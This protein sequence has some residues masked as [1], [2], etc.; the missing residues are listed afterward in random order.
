MRYSVGTLRRYTEQAKG[1]LN[2]V[3]RLPSGE[4]AEL[5][6]V[7]S[8]GNRKIGAAP[9]VSLLPIITCGNCGKCMWHCYDIKAC[10]RLPA[11]MRARVVNTAIY[12]REPERFFAEIDEALTR[13]SPEH[14]FR[15]HQGG[16]IPDR[17]YLGGM[18]ETA[19][20]H[21]EWSMWTYTHMHGWV[22][23]WLSLPDN[24]SIM[25]SEDDEPADNPHGRPVF[26]CIPKGAPIPEGYHLCG[27]DCQACRRSGAGCPAGV[28][29][30]VYEH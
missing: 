1:A 11:V 19:R 6:V 15:W 10:L 24:L 26:K 14:G 22:N 12:M 13:M 29:S 25:Y 7:V 16:E 17:E 30:V 27:G 9:N 8:K 5:H 4:F 20:K 21:P 2:E 3:L 23:E 28:S 18:V